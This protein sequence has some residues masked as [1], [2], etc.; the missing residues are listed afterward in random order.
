MPPSA[1]LPLG[2]SALLALALCAQTLGQERAPEDDDRPI[3][4]RPDPERLVLSPDTRLHVVSAYKGWRAGAAGEPGEVSVHVSAGPTP[5]VVVLTAF[6]SVRWTV[7]ADPEARLEG[8]VLSGRGPQALRAAPE[9]APVVEVAGLFV[10][11]PMTPPERA[12]ATMRERQER[13]ARELE[14]KKAALFERLATDLGRPVGT[15]QA[16]YAARSFVVKHRGGPL[17]A[18]AEVRAL[19]TYSASS[20][21]SGQDGRVVVEVAASPVPWVLVLAAYETVHWELRLEEGARVAGV[22][23]GGYHSQE[24][25]GLPAQ[26][27][28]VL[29]R[30]FFLTAL[31]GAQEAHLREQVRLTVGQEPARVDLVEGSRARVE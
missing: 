28:T 16:C 6:Q 11:A 9:G 27:V 10:G 1:L 5:A 17:P 4:E 26:D 30:S 18:R 19:S 13:D 2:R 7:T 14:A 22:I 29:Q 3:L 24:V 8:I 25:S 20:A 15:F 12:S 23:L 31:G 21:S